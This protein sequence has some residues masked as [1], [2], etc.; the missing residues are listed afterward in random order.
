MAVEKWPRWGSLKSR[1]EWF[2][3]FHR[4][5]RS[6]EQ[7]QTREQVDP[8]GDQQFAETRGGRFLGIRSTPVFGSTL[9]ERA[10]TDGLSA[11]YQE[12]LS[13]SYDCV[14]RIV[15]NAYFGPRDSRAGQAAAPHEVQPLP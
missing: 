8:E 9:G 15:L 3:H 6:D 10:M 14:D 12:L 11:L 2:Y 13:G 7:G 4:G 5:H 1:T